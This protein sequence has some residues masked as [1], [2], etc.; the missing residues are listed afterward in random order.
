MFRSSSF[1]KI[2]F[3]SAPQ[4]TNR[5]ALQTL[6]KLTGQVESLPL[7]STTGDTGYLDVI[8]DPGDAILLKYDTG[9][10]FVLQP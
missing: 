5:T 8:L 4:S 10:P 6:N 2:D 7:S 1:S 3:T 9:A